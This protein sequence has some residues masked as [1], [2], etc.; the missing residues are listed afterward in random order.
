MKVAL[1]M[2]MFYLS[3]IQSHKLGLCILVFHRLSQVGMNE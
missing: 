2:L 1:E 3:F